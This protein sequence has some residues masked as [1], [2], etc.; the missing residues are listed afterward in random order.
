MMGT[1]NDNP[2]PI[3]TIITKMRM[4]QF[5]LSTPFPLQEEKYLAI[6]LASGQGS[7]QATTWP[8]MRQAMTTAASDDVTRGKLNYYCFL[9]LNFKLKY[10]T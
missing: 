10:T 8:S 6:I 5:H 1:P 7:S 2:A 9:P 3:T 4:N